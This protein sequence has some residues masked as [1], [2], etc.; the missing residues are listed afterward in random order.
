MSDSNYKKQKFIDMR[1]RY[2]SIA[3]IILL[4]IASCN[5]FLNLQPKDNVDD[6]QALTSENSIQRALTGTY[7]IMQ[8]QEYY[9]FEWMNAVWLGEDNVA[10]FGSS[11]TDLQFDG[12]SILASSNTIDIIWK[13]MY[14]TINNAN[15]V[16]DAATKFFDPGF[17]AA[18]KNSML[19]QALF[20]RALV[21]F[22]LVRSFGGVPIVLTPTR[23]LN[24]NSYPARNTVA[25]VYEQVTKD[26]DEAEAKLTASD[27][28]NL[29][30]KRAATALKA[31]LNL[32]L[33]NWLSAEQNATVVINDVAYS[34][35]KPFENLIT[36]KNTSEAIFELSY[37]TTD[38]NPISN[39]FLPTSLN[40][41][42]RVGPT[43]GLI[44]LLN[45]QAAGG[46]RKVMLAVDANGIPYGNKYRTFRTTGV[47]NDDV[48]VI[49]LAEMYLIRAEARAKQNNLNSAI[50]DLNAI[51]TRADVASVIFTP[52]I[53]RD[54][55]LLYIENERRLEFAFEPHRW[56]DLI[57]TGRAGDVLGVTDGRKYI[58]PLP[59][60]DVLTNTNLQQNPG[61]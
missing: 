30:T 14:Q 20:I 10:P 22:D 25:E 41:G 38:T 53:T 48:V 55:V 7:S 40:G 35:V 51:R 49:R 45:D 42:Y 39:V 16:I 12:H 8:Q 1:T 46:T 26:L 27:E 5:D 56:F 50:E 29:A 47:S 11:T 58:F 43:S 4:G 31:R 36:Q 32:Y 6:S 23:G 3:A 19:G 57:R 59:A 17:T 28:R 34:L 24:A 9:G 33:G 18:E 52:A 61:Y 2:I 37:N 15:N 21:Y 44:A 60:N 54:Q 13:A